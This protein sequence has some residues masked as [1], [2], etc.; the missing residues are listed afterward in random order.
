M[1]SMQLAMVFREDRFLR[2]GDHRQFADRGF[3]AVRLTTASENYANQHSAT[4]TF[5]NT[6]V[7][8]TTR[9]AK[10]NGAVAA[11]LALAP[12]ANAEF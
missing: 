10:I 9:V 4:D 6:S 7:P 5:A 8:Y 3:A 11:S 2:G 12:A 1:P